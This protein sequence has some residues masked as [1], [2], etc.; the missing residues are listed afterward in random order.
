FKKLLNKYPN[1]T[2]NDL[3]LCS[4][5]KMNF[6][7]KEIARLLNNSTRAVEISRYR[8][9]KKLNLSHDE[10]LTEFLISIDFDNLQ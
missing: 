2:T 1:L 7:T 9:R 6:S 5:L 10:N 8:L 3:R 4:Y